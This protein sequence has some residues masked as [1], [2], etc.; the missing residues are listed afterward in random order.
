MRIPDHFQYHRFS[1]T[2]SHED[3]TIESYC[4]SCLL[5]YS[6]FCSSTWKKEMFTG[7]CCTCLYSQLD[8]RKMPS[9]LQI[10]LTANDRISWFTENNPLFYKA[11]PLDRR[12]KKKASY[13]RNKIMDQ[14]DANQQS[15]KLHNDTRENNICIMIHGQSDNAK[16]K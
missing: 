2:K 5:L 9:L 11:S 8:G 12:S 10:Y 3:F 4:S 16:S 14:E 15:M 7:R 1:S 13:G 6:S